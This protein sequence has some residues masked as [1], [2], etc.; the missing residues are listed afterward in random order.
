MTGNWEFNTLDQKDKT[1]SVSQWIEGVK[2]GSE[3]SRQ[4]IW[5]RYYSRLVGLLR[6]QLNQNERR[7]SDEEDI[8]S[9][10]FFEIFRAM[11]EGRLES[12]DDRDGLWRV[13]VVIADQK[14]IDQRRYLGRAKRGGGQVRGHS[15]FMVADTDQFDQIPDPSPDF[16]EQFQMALSESLGTLRQDLRKIAVWKM[17]GHTNL[18]IAQF[19]GCVE[20]SV[21]RKVLLIREQLSKA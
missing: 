3:D 7:T 12:V 17:A 5:N 16:V 15:A 9:S 14:M 1:L 8:A 19:L 18:E 13:L 20:E 10:A 2:L 6:S 11:D 21:R 4:E